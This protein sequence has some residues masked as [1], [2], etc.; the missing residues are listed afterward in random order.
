MAGGTLSGL[1]ED[2]RPRY[3][4][5]PRPAI[6]SV[7]GGDGPEGDYTVAPGATVAL[8]GGLRRFRNITIGSGAIVN[9][10][11]GY[12][13]LRAS[14]TV[15]IAG[16]INLSPLIAGGQSFS[17]VI[18][19]QMQMQANPGQGLGGAAGHNSGP[20]ASY[21]FSAEETG[22]SGASGFIWNF[23]LSNA[24]VNLTSSTGGAGGGTLVIEA[25]GAISVTGTINC[26]GGNGTAPTISIADSGGGST[27]L[28]GGGGGSGG[29]IWLQSQIGITC[30]AAST[31]SVRGGNGG[32]GGGANLSAGPSQGG[33]GGGGGWLVFSSP[34][35]QTTG[36]T[37]TVTGGTAGTNQAGGAGVGV[38]GSN[39]GSYAGQGGGGGSA[40][41]VGQVVPLNF[42]PI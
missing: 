18:M 33:G 32:N 11:P 20:K 16:T 19:P 17:G 28:T 40:G 22:S 26:N 9:V 21:S 3:A 1:I 10:S 27:Y 34:F 6:L 24:G 7:F 15:T 42:L 23:G 12:L 35:N 5:T 8:A 31:L 14:G 29:L 2:L 38:G 41:S 37:L 39:G 36:S 25:A 4:V 30:S 13:K